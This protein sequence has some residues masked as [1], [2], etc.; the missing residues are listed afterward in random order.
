VKVSK[1]YRRE[2]KRAALAILS[3]LPMMVAI[4]GLVGLFQALV[5]PERLASLFRGNAV[6]DTLIGT[7]AGMIAVG[8]P[9]VSYILGGELL[10]EGISLYAVTA[11]V[12]A[13]VTLGVVQLPLEA[14]MLGLRFTFWRNILAFCFTIILAVL[15]VGTIQW[16]R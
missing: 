14:E 12:L 8:Q 9:I 13:W 3:I 11:F 4:L 15:T 16:L 7:V 10:K 5:T 1:S 2:L 6:A